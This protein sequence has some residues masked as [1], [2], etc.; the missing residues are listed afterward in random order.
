MPP[1]LGL[2]ELT[3]DRKASWSMTVARNIWKKPVAAPH[4]IVIVI[5]D[6]TIRHADRI[7]HRSR[8]SARRA[9]GML[10]AA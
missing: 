2:H 6:Q 7:I 4:S 8:G 10:A 1:K 5:V 3:G 9:S